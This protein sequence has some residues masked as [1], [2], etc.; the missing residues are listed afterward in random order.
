M[1]LITLFKIVLLFFVSTSVG[2]ELIRDWQV[3]GYRVFRERAYLIYLHSEDEQAKR[4]EHMKLF[5]QMELFKAAN[6]ENADVYERFKTMVFRDAAPIKFQEFI[7]ALM[8]IDVL[9]ARND[10][11][12]MKQ[13]VALFVFD[14]LLGNKGLQDIALLD[15][16]E[17]A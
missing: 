6:P 10:S 1:K 7:A 9:L 5:V 13:R 14:L 15:T 8:A 12:E 4:E 3:E 11:E 16:R 17:M 2:T